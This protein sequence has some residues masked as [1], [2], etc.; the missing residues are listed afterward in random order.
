MSQVPSETASFIRISGK[1]LHIRQLGPGL[2]GA[3]LV[4]LHEGLGSVDLWRGFPDDVVS[5]SG[6]PGLVYS[7]YGNGWSTPLSG[8]RRPGYM[9]EEALETLP[10]VVE[11][12]VEERPILI[13]HSDG[14]SIALIYAG[15]GHPVV[16]LVLIAPHVFVEPQTV[17]SIAT[18]RDDFA[19]SDMASRMSKY[20]AEPETT[21]RGWADVWLS[22]EFRDWNIEEYVAGIRCPTLLVQGEED[23]YGTLSQ[24]D[25]IDASLGTPAD[26]L[27]VAGAGHAPHLSHP[28]QVTEGVVGFVSGLES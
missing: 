10:Q 7:R 6:H 20:H 12:S 3:P 21:F 14:A 17:G 5:A 22:P 9:H 2:D 26:R 16:G 23:E 18:I 27:V 25:A 13:G 8:P 15:A 24:L 19:A 1:K 4:F 11:S 28:Q